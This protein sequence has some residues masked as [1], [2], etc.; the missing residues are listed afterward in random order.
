MTRLVFFCCST[1]F[2]D[3]CC[4]LFFL[5]SFVS[6]VF[7]FRD[8][9]AHHGPLRR[10]LLLHRLPVHGVAFPPGF[11]RCL[12]SWVSVSPWA[13]WLVCFFVGVCF[14]WFLA[15]YSVAVSVGLR[16]GLVCP[17]SPPPSLPPC[18]DFL[19]CA[20]CICLLHLGSNQWR[21]L[22][23]NGPGPHRPTTSRVCLDL[24]PAGR[25]QADAWGGG[26]VG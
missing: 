13:K 21:I 22:A 2:D 1:D 5:C 11:F 10:V 7:C 18:V 24:P 19:C 20:S 15:S 4:W 9:G 26:L 16:F 17:P 14:F 8:D 12:F 3:C 25:R 23:R 6:L